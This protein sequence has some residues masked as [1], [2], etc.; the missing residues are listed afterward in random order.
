[1]QILVDASV[2]IDYFQGV[3]SEPTDT[4][5]ALLGTAPLMVAGLSV[6]EILCGLPDEH[7]R[8]LAQQALLQFWLVDL[9]GLDLA[10]DSAVYYHTLKNRGIEA[11]PIHCQIAAFCLKY[12]FAL[13]ASDPV[14][15]AME[16]PLG[17]TLARR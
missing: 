5:D 3:E 16:R 4:L 1:V 12:G 14:F 8:K 13:L 15:A 2:W 9:A 17:L 11:Q 7:H 6:A 10:V